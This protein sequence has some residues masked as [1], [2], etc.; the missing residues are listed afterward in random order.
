MEYKALELR[1]GFTIFIAVMIFTIGLMWFEGFKLGGE[2][3]EFYAIFPMVGGIDPGDAVH[4]NGVEKGEVKSV[5]LREQD[6]IITMELD[7]SARIPEDSK[8]VLQ[9]RGI[10][11]E[12]IVS[13][14]MGSSDVM[15]EGG[16]LLEGVYDPGIS[17]ALAA[18]GNVIEEI[19]RLVDDIEMVTRQ[20]TDGERLS[21]AIDNLAGVSERVRNAL[22][23]N[24]GSMDSGI[25]SF[26]RSAS[27][28]DSM[29]ARN[30]AHVDS[31]MLRFDDVSRALPGLIDNISK[32]TSTLGELVARLET[33][34][35]TMGALLQ[36]R[37]LLDRL[38]KTIGGLDSL[39]T[40]IRENPKKYLKLEIF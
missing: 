17:E 25:A 39:V 8:V 31:M 18:V 15:L 35:N 40:D 29:L 24:M 21:N 7:T 36:D 6:V 33:N 34:D 2:K 27:R 14:I 16:A 10:M 19:T 4:V 12:R 3:Y 32:V 11:G 20:L 26:S 13:I 9:T 30:T 5:S 23:R 38:E 28:I 1:V 37:E 22:D